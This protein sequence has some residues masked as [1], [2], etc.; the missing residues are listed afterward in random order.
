LEEKQQSLDDLLAAPKDTEVQVARYAVEQKQR[1][2]AEAE[3]TLA[4]YTITARLM[5]Q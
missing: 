4:K 1:A 2:L 3:K 5:A